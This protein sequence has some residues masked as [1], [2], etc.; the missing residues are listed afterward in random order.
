MTRHHTIR[1]KPPRQPPRRRRAAAP[2]VVRGEGADRL[3][4]GTPVV[5]S[6]GLHPRANCK[7]SAPLPARPKLA[8]LRAIPTRFEC[9][10]HL[11]E[12]RGV[13]GS[14]PGLAIGS[15]ES[16][17]C[18]DSLAGGA[19][20]LKLRR[21]RAEIVVVFS[22][23]RVD[24]NPLAYG[25]F[26]VVSLLAIRG[27]SGRRSQRSPRYRLFLRL[28]LVERLTRGRAARSRAARGT[29]EPAPLVGAIRRER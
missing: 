16:R 21:T 18:V 17:M 28:G 4:H 6:S 26:R 20:I 5:S 1:M 9:C 15:P 27:R 2:S 19:T 13:P 11:P 24:A 14:S 10:V 8:C 3:G 29:R 22:S 7:T 25:R 12:N 23:S